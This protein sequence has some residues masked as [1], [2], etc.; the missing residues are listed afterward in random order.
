MWGWQRGAPD[1]NP[2]FF[3]YPTLS[4]YLHFLVQ[5]LHY[6]IGRLAGAFHTRS[7]YLVSYFLDPTPMVVAGRLLGVLADIATVIGIGVLGERVRRGAGLAAAALVT[8]SPTMILDSR[9]IFCDMC[10]LF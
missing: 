6:A 9:S 2:H 10:G 8:F 1:L 7:D 4:F 5:N 3:F